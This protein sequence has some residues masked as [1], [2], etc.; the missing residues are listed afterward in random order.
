MQL[1]NLTRQNI[2]QKKLQLRQLV[3]DSYRYDSCAIQLFSLVSGCA[4][5]CPGLPCKQPL[6]VAPSL[7][8]SLCSLTLA[9]ISLRAQTR[10]SRSQRTATS[11]CPMS[12]LS[13]WVTISCSN[14]A[15]PDAAV[16]T[17]LILHSI[18]LLWTLYDS[19]DHLSCHKRIGSCAPGWQPAARTGATVKNT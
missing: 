7:R 11:S 8:R 10:S 9:G 16:G 3:G 1:E 17:P 14:S 19:P 4:L 13:R 12:R 2:E 18:L 15:C 6:A 5:V